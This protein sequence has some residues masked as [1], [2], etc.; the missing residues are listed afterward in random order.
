[1]RFYF[2]DSNAV[3]KQY[4]PEIGSEWI[5]QLTHE[6]TSKPFLNLIPRNSLSLLYLLLTFLDFVEKILI[7]HN[8]YS[9]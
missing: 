4:I 6:G 8:L 2:L 9:F 1:M 5:Q 7:Q 3:V